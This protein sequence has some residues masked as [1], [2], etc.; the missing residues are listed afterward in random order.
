L[1]GHVEELNAIA[2]FFARD[3]MPFDNRADVTRAETVLRDIG[4]QDNVLEQLKG[5]HRFSAWF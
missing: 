3:D 4:S 1:P 5:H 2:L